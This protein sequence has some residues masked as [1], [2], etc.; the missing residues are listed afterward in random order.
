MDTVGLLTFGFVLAAD[1]CLDQ[2]MSLGLAAAGS[3]QAL[4]EAVAGVGG[5]VRR[6][7]V[8]LLWVVKLAT[9]CKGVHCMARLVL[10][11][12][13][14]ADSECAD[15]GFAAVV[16]LLVGGSRSLMVAV[17]VLEQIEELQMLY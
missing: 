9:E 12:A 16:G 10:G 14:I 13:H 8:G 2:S 3:V 7:L 5:L 1:S 4:V 17:V 15:A 6:R 11:S